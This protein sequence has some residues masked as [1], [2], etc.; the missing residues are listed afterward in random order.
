M[1]INTVNLTSI[2]ELEGGTSG[3]I[4]LG[5]INSLVFEPSGSPSLNQPLVWSFDVFWLCTSRDSVH[6]HLASLVCIQAPRL[7]QTAGRYVQFF[8]GKMEEVHHF[9]CYLFYA[10]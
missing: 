4:P 6:G 5:E 3:D 1:K 7:Q 2:T 8:V 9:Q 10:S